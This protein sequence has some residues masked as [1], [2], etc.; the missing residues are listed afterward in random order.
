[1]REN[2]FTS[3]TTRLMVSFLFMLSL[4]LFIQGHNYPGGGFIA[5]LVGSAAI[6]ALYISRSSGSG[7]TA[8][9]RM[10]ANF[11]GYVMFLGIILA[12]LSGLWGLFWGESFMAAAWYEQ[13]IPGVGKLGT[14]L[15]FDFGIFLSVIGVTVSITRILASVRHPDDYYKYSDMADADADTDGDGAEPGQPDGAN[16]S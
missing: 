5:G 8:R 7:M 2:L 13:E 9:H 10:G 1:M 3:F 16:P 14:P 15:L 12:M 6:I 4:Y 11:W